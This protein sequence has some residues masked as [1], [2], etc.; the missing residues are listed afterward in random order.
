MGKMLSGPHGGIF[1][2]NTTSGH[3]TKSAC[4]LRDGALSSSYR[5]MVSNMKEER[6]GGGRKERRRKG[7]RMETKGRGEGWEKRWGKTE[8]R[9]KVNKE[10]RQERK[11]KIDEVNLKVNVLL[12]CWSS[13]LSL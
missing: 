3:W 11:V 2:C 1:C 4:R 13:D 5:S 6:R 8:G 10:G 7:E 9:E 12:Y